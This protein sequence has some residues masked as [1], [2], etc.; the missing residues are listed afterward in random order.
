M[1]KCLNAND[2]YIVMVTVRSK[3]WIFPAVVPVLHSKSGSKCSLCGMKIVFFFLENCMVVNMRVP[4]QT[5]M[6]LY[7]ETNFL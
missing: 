3:K 5:H 7:I 6:H 2:L 1:L 4:M